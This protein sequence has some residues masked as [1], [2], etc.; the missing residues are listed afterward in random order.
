MVKFNLKI[1]KRGWWFKRIFGA[2]EKK[3]IN[4]NLERKRVLERIVRLVLIKARKIKK[5]E[6]RRI[7]ILA[8][9]IG[10]FYR[11]FWK[12]KIF[13]SSSWEHLNFIR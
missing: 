4:F 10:K 8:I 12:I 11:N 7:I 13:T 9:R 3:L 5:I 2:L 1:K 6:K